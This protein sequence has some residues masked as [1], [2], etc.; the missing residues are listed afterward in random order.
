MRMGSVWMRAGLG[1]ALLLSLNAARAQGPRGEPIAAPSSNGFL[2]VPPPGTGGTLAVPAPPVNQYNVDQNGHGEAHEE[3]GHHEGEEGCHEEEGRGLYVIGEYLFV[4]PR[5]RAFDFVINDP[6]LDNTVNGKVENLDWD[7]QSAYRLGVGYRLGHGWEAGATYFYLHSKDNESR[8]AS[9]TGA[10]FATLTAP[11]IDQVNTA[12]ASTNLDMDIIDAELANRFHGCNGDLE[13]RLAAG[14]RVA[15]IQQ[16]LIAAYSGATAGAGTVVSSP[17]NFDGIGLKAGG[18][19]W[20]K[21]RGNFGVYARANLSMLTGDFRTHLTQT[22]NGGT[23]SLID[24]ADKFHKVVP[25]TEL[26]LGV[27]WQTENLRVSVG[28]EI[29]N[30]FNMVDSVD[31]VEGSSFGK[32]EH[33]QSDLSYD[34]LAVSIGLFF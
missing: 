18:E 15:T 8:T 7:T 19:A 3:N 25:I 1:M 14:V 32:I 10:L 6:T 28:Y 20:Y 17:V 33:R 9:P 29:T 34:G 24:V 26:G 23:T 4:R 2:A 13:V 22:I 11:G 31:F 21:V 16:K 27:A 5:R 30:F 12:T